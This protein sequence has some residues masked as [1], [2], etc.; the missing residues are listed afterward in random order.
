MKNGSA[1]SLR[2]R[3]SAL[4]IGIAFL[5][6]NR[7]ITQTNQ[8]YRD[9]LGYS[10]AEILERGPKGLLHPGDWDATM[11]MR[12]RFRSGDLPLF[13]M[14]Q[15]Y[16][17]KDGQV[18]WSDT[19]ITALRDQEGRLVHTIGWVQD[20]TERKRAEE[21]LRKSEEQY[22]LLF[23]SIQD[24][25]LMTDIERTI[26]D[27]N[28]AFIRLFGY[29]HDEIVGKKTVVLYERPEQF[30]NL[31]EALKM[32]Q[33]DSPFMYQIN[34]KKKNEEVFAGE[35][36]ISFLTDSSGNRI[37]FIGLIKDI[38]E[39]KHAEEEKHL[40]EEERLKTQKL[41]AVGT[42][43]RGIAHDFNN[44]LQGVFGYISPLPSSGEMTGKRAWQ[45]LRSPKMHF[46]CQSSLRTSYLP[47]QKVAN[48]LKKRS[49][50]LP[51]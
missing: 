25:I 20:I 33:S 37:G 4:P 30:D 40:L 39:K 17:R 48:P 43:A 24:C 8:R 28:P 34:Y 29:T 13:H 50:P 35:V 9:F 23:N 19:I 12:T 6:L 32:R 10:E 51:S 44:L 3:P 46:T 38:T 26:I 27:V 16:I 14:E 45:H 21:L 36:A 42:L 49:S 22:R 47:S 41:E 31:V 1:R 2:N 18:V 7:Q 15:R 11:A 5:D